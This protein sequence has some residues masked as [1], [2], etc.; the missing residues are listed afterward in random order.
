MKQEGVLHSSTQSI[1]WNRA[2]TDEKVRIMRKLV[3]VLN[4]HTI[5]DVGSSCGIGKNPSFSLENLGIESKSYCV[6]LDMDRSMLLKAKDAHRSS[7]FLLADATNLPLRDEGIDLLFSS[8]V[9]EHLVA[10]EKGLDEWS[11]V[12][13]K[14]GYVIVTTPNTSLSWR[15][16]YIKF[17]K[18][19]KP[20]QGHIAE[21]DVRDLCKSLQRRPLKVLTVLGFNLVFVGPV[22]F[23]IVYFRYFLDIVNKGASMKFNESMCRLGRN[24]P[25]FSDSVLVLCK[26]H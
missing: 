2:Y 4:F 18:R 14:E 23:T 19:G 26:K 12:V 15:S 5:L 22:R 3:T 20:D 8:E 11:R 16:L 7:Y 9:L 13:K 24:Y 21:Y 25:L 17:V 10:P 6:H 1:G